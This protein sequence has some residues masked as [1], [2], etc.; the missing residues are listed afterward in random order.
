M[1]VIFSIIPTIIGIIIG[2]LLCFLLFAA[3][4]IVVVPWIGFKQFNNVDI[5]DAEETIFKNQLKRLQEVTG[6]TFLHT[7]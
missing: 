2:L 7:P 5:K 1:D 3:I 6:M 4:V